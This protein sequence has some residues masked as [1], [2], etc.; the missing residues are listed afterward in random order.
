MGERDEW[1]TLKKWIEK[2]FMTRERD[3]WA[4]VFHGTDSCVT[5]VLSPEEAR[6]SLPADASW[7]PAHPDLRRGS[8]PKG[9]P[10]PELLNPGDHT[11]EILKEFG[12]NETE[13]RWLAL[14]GALGE[15]VRAK[16]KS[17]RS[18]L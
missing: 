3:Y 10:D 11:A 16:A 1:P 15:E 14:D 18:K 6:S 5:P 13:Q 9:G 4:G 12:I 17:S 7:P 2:A 8:T